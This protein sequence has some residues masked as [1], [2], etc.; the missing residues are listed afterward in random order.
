MS[1]F[2]LNVQQNYLDSFPDY[3]NKVIAMS[4]SALEIYLTKRRKIIV[5]RNGKQPSSL[6]AV[7]TFN[8]NL[9][10]LGFVCSQELTSALAGLSE[11]AL[12]SLYQQVVPILKTM[13]GAHRTFKPMYP[14]FPKQVMEASDL[15]LY[16]NAITHYWMAAVRDVAQGQ[17][18]LFGGRLMEGAANTG[19]P[20]ASLIRL[21]SAL[22][23][24]PKPEG[25]SVQSS[26][27]QRL[28]AGATEDP[29]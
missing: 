27:C 7:A 11:E 5:Q 2:L 18:R 29:Y 12:G 1:R 17:P 23:S 16:L 3:F 13:T 20:R 25:G 24:D 19:S 10:S 15:E 26:T 4:L 28:A 9:I 21:A 14:N 6:A 22:Q 8:R